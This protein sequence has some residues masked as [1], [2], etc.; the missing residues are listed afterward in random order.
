MG[1]KMPVEEVRSGEI[2]KV[3]QVRKETTHK[4]TE[5]PVGVEE[6]NAEEGVVA[7]AS[8]QPRTTPANKTNRS[9]KLKGTSATLVS[10]VSMAY[11]DVTSCHELG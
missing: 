1:E 5:S 8:A 9:P 11:I 6:E 10:V 3:E 2:V 7:P 4:L